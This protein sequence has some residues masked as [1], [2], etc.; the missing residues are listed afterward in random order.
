MKISMILAADEYGGIG[1]QNDLP[2]P[3]I[4][5]DMKWFMDHTKDN[6]VVMGSKTWKSLGI[7]K[8]LKD[9]INYVIS[10]QDF[11]LFEGAY[12]SYDPTQYSMDSIVLAIASRHPNK[13][14]FVIGGKTVYDE[15]YKSCNKIYLTRVEGMHTVDTTVDIE[16]YLENFTCTDKAKH[17]NPYPQPHCTFEIWERN[18]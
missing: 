12:D 3:K 10:S 18:A 2:W 9:R 5:I 7:H 15:A 16:K 17:V 8:P 14:I 11:K 1:Y 6:V 4:I 13:E